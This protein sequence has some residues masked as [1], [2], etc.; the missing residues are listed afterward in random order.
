MKV[1]FDENIPMAMVRV[2]QSFSKEHQILRLI[3]GLEV[4]YAKDYA[5]A[6]TDKDYIKKSDVPWI[7]RFSQAG[8]KV[9]ISGNTRMMSVEAER[10]ALVEEGMIVFFPD[11][12]WN[13]LRFFDK[14]ALLLR[15]W[16]QLAEIAKT[17]SAPSFW[18][19]PATWK[20]EAGI[21]QVPH[22]DQSLERVERQKAEG[23]A[24]REA[25][26][27]NRP[28]PAQTQLEGLEAPDHDGEA[29]ES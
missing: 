5:P 24:K 11:G 12:S 26:K 19:I 27:A 6:R 25:R 23:L 9:I 16:P 14:C 4:A 2:F 21:V 18:R 10:L 13:G 29:K 20:S 8:G 22:T 7:K 3:P 1:A 17:A 15:W 28:D